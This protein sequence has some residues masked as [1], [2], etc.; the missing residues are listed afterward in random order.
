MSMN[1]VSIKLVSLWFSSSYSNDDGSGV[2]PYRSY[3]YHYHSN[4]RYYSGIF[5]AEGRTY[6][7]ASHKISTGPNASN[8]LA[9]LFSLDVKFA[10]IFQKET[11]C[12]ATLYG[13]SVHLYNRFAIDHH[14]C[15]VSGNIW[16]RYISIPRYLKLRVEHGG[17]WMLNCFFNLHTYLKENTICPNYDGQLG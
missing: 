4:E 8:A 5:C 6:G 3:H 2:C 7:A 10:N 1:N 9:E 15:I 16:I 17:Y 11:E 14:R 13:I 12:S